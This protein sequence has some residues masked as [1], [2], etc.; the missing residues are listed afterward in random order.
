MRLARFAF[1]L[2]LASAAA[3]PAQPPASS[4]SPSLEELGFPPRTGF[5]HTRGAFTVQFDTLPGSASPR[6]LVDRLSPG[7]KDEPAAIDPRRESW[8][9]FV[10][11]EYDPATPWGLWVW[12]SPTDF[13]GVLR[14][15]L[16]ALLARERLIWIGAHRADNE[17]AP[18]ERLALALTAAELAPLHW[19]IDPWR[20]YVSGY[21][22]GGRLASALATFW[23]EIFRGGLFVK[24]CNWYAPLAVPGQPGRIWQPA[25]R[26]PPRQTARLLHEE[27]RFVYLTGE[28]DFN[29]D[30]IRATERAARQA[31]FR[32][33]LLLEAPGIDHL[34]PVPLE[35]WQRAMDFLGGTD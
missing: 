13:G 12:L 24:G 8:F 27:R 29:R 9:V 1:G 35:Y 20:V 5:D 11:A 23:P 18:L 4:R 2:L 32:H 6:A 10:P 3:L 28:K 33:T 25:F 15:D 17:R 31:G 14:D 7:S 21:S 22:G 26:E 34:G 19:T 16:R 30:E